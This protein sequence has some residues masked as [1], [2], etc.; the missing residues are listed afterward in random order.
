MLGIS[1]T[2]G[3]P[4]ARHIKAICLCILMLV[5]GATLAVAQEVTGTLTGRVTD[6]NSAAVS[7]ARVTISNT[8]RGFERAFSTTEDG[9]FSA[10]LLPAGN[11][12]I[13]VESANFKRYLQNDVQLSVNDR[14]AVDI[15]LEAGAVTETVEVTADAPLLQESPTQQGLID[16]TQVKQLPLVSRNFTQLATLSAGVVAQPQGSLSFGALA[17]VNLSIN[18]GRASAVNYLVDGARN[19]DTGSNL[20]L[21][22]VPSVDAIQEFTVLTSNY[23]PEFGRNGGG[24]I[25]V[26]TRGGTNNFNGTLYEFFRNDALNARD[27]FVTT[28]LAGLGSASSPRFRQPLR[29]NNFG[30]TVGG[31]V[32]FPRFGEGGPVIYNGRDKTFFF[33]S[34]E[35]RRIRATSTPVGTVPTVNQRNGIITSATAIN[36]PLRPGVSYPSVGGFVTIPRER[37]DPN[38]RAI[39]A[40]IP[41][42]NEGTNQFRRVTPVAANFRQ[43]I[44]RFDHNFGDTTSL[45]ARYIRDN[46]TRDDPGGNIF[47]DPFVRTNT[48]GT[49][50]PFVAAQQTN[51][52]GDSFVASLRFAISPTSINEIAFDYARNVIQSTFVGTGTRANNPG[53]TA[54]ELFPGSLNDALPGITFSSAIANLTFQSPQDIENPSYTV[55]DNLTLVRDNHTLKFG[56]FLSR[57]AKNENA[58]NALNGSFAFNTTRS[59][60]D[61]AD[62]LLGAPAS[63]IEDQNEVRVELRYNTFEFYGQDTWKITPRFTLDYGARYSV[64]QNPVEQSDFL[65]AFLPSLYDPARRL[66]QS[67][68]R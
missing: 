34:Q 40:L 53:F 46:F 60:N 20:T 3:Y 66:N 68:D 1:T 7:G 39:L 15:E 59:G 65:T 33:F 36:D 5:S 32:F 44:V 14:R 54:P 50:Y 2:K 64:F 58:G 67:D 26:V 21:L 62:L 29:Y 16:G 45:Y 35:F 52:P 4:I 23:A 43:E 25:N 37:I 24:V 57:E 61:F 9:T 56:A 18:G 13:T 38:A 63:Y 17:V 48:A 42:P 31:P 11:Y 49:L 8:E 51:T 28:P 19:V 10:P 41:S 6:Q 30:Y 47:L 22:T 55:R 27:P 12:T